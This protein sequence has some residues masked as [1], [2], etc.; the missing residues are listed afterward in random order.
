MLVLSLASEED[1]KTD[2]VFVRP[3]SLL[4]DVAIEAG[5]KATRVLTTQA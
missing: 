3:M 4:E 1:E 2:K 5:K